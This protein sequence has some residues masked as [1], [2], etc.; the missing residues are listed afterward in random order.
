MI[1]PLCFPPPKSARTQSKE[2]EKKE[3]LG[4]TKYTYRTYHPPYPSLAYILQLLARRKIA[5]I[6]HTYFIHKEKELLVRINA[7]TCSILPYIAAAFGRNE[8]FKC[9]SSECDIFSPLALKPPDQKKKE[10]KV[11]DASFSY[12]CSPISGNKLFPRNA[13]EKK[14]S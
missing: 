7:H 9:C 12:Y 5:T 3:G 6:H 11:G 13:C 4:R 1:F 8:S 14:S 2:F 10:E